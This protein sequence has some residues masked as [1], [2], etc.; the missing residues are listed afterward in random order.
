MRSNDRALFESLAAASEAVIGV[1]DLDANVLWVSDGLIAM[2]GYTLDDYKFQRFENPYIPAEDVAVVTEFLADF[3]ATEAT[4]SGVVRNRFVDRWGGTLHVRSRIAKIT[5]EGQSA[6]LYSIV[7]QDPQGKQSLEVEQRYRSLVEAASDSIVRLRPDLTVQF[8]NPCFRE[9]MGRTAAELNRLPF[10]ELVVPEERGAVIDLLRSTQE[11]FQVTVAALDREGK[12]IWLEATFVRIP[13]GPDAGL[14]Q[15][16]LRDTTQRRKLDA[17]VHL[18]Q[19][20]ETLGQMAGGI[21]HD[22]N[23]ILTGILGSATVAEREVPP[24]GKVAGALADIRIAALR[25][26]QL[27]SSMLVYAGE[28]STEPVAVDLVELVGEMKSLLAS[29]L[30]KNIELRFETPSRRVGVRADPVQLRQVVMNLITN[31][32][33]AVSGAGGQVTVV[34]GQRPCTPEVDVSAHLFGTPPA[35]GTTA[36]VRVTDDGSGMSDAVI[37]RIFDPFYST[38]GQGR[39]LGLAAVIGIVDQHGGCIRVQSEVGVG[40]QIEI[41][42]PVFAEP[43]P[44]T[45]QTGQ[46]LA[47]ADRLHTILVVD[48]DALIR[49]VVRRSL[50]PLG[51]KII[52]ADSGEAAIEVLK[53]GDASVSA[54]LLDETMPGMGGTQTLVEVRVLNP[55]M[56]VIRMSGYLAGPDPTSSTSDDCIFMLQ[57][58][59]GVRELAQV[60]RSVLGDSG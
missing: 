58:P 16:V 55:T 9:L 49:K 6:L 4:L 53:Q 11:R 5:W 25:A 48:D 38:K 26:G 17:R 41:E 59:F 54:V 47:T 20:R 10:G 18:A 43:L 37:G 23:N 1:T 32:A 40:T 57:K 24:H 60:V 39:G 30:D 29:G 31:A 51:Y 52:E 27:S 12:T 13:S 42:L 34:A 45:K 7:A 15:A 36:F 14:L 44:T 56:P 8:S 33:D 50:Q 3:L 2:T 35:N 22:L 46:A 21:A 28:G 19:K